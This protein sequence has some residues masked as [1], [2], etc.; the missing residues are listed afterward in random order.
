MSKVTINGFMHCRPCSGGGKPEFL[1]F[2]C[3]MAAHSPDFGVCIGPVEFEYELPAGFDTTAAQVAAIDKQLADTNCRFAAAVR[4]LE[5]RR[6]NLLALT[7]ESE[8]A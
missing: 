1:F 2:S 7:Y 4:A 3:D 6:S 8:A 5:E